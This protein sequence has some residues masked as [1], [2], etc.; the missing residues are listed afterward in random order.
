MTRPL[1]GM[2]RS[3]LPCSDHIERLLTWELMLADR[4]R[5]EMGLPPRTVPQ[6]AGTWTCINMH[7]APA[8]PDSQS[9]A[10]PGRHVAGV[11]QIAFGGFYQHGLVCRRLASYDC[12][13]MLDPAPQ[14]GAMCTCQLGGEARLHGMRC[15]MLGRARWAAGRP[16]VCHPAGVCRPRSDGLNALWQSLTR[17]LPA[18]PCAARHLT[19]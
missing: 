16:R 1:R 2:Q 17:V 10:P 8:D 5:E 11:K 15:R 3:D 7:C 4:M 6:P 9:A 13:L 14:V 19:R 18:R 12:T